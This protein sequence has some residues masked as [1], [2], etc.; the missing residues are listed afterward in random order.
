MAQDFSMRLP[1]VDPHGN[2]GSLDDSPAAS[3]YTEC[4]LSGFGL[5][6]LD[7]LDE[8]AVDFLPNYD[9]T[10]SEPAVLP[11]LFPNLL[12]NGST[13]V[14][15][16]MATNIPPHNLT[17]VLDASILLLTK[18]AS[19][20]DLLQVVKGPDF[21]TGGEIVSRADLRDLYATGKGSVSVRAKARIVDVSPRRKGIE[22]SELPYMV[23]PEKVV[24]RIRDLVGDKRLPAVADVKDFSDRT[25]GLRLVV[26]VKP[27]FDPSALLADL[28]RL[29]PME[30][31]F[32][33]SFVALVEGRP[34]VCSLRDL[35]Q[36]F[37]DHRLET[38]RRRSEFQLHR[39]RS[40]AHLQEALVLALDDV[41]AVVRL[42]R[43]ASDTADARTK[44][45]KRL[46][47]DATQ[48]DYVLEMP[49][50]RLTSLE[51]GK[52]R[53]DL[54]ALY[55][56]IS[57]LESLLASPK[58]LAAAVVSELS[59]LR[60]RFPSPRRTALSPS[61]TPAPAAVSVSDSP[62]PGGGSV[63]HPSQ[64]LL[65]GLTRS[66]SL[67]RILP[68]LG[69]ARPGV[70][71]AIVS[72]C[73]AGLNDRLLAISSSGRAYPFSP[74]EVPETL[75][76][77]RG[78][79]PVDL[80]PSFPPAENLVAVLPVSVP[81]AL[82]TARGVVKRLDPVSLP[83]NLGAPREQGF[84]LVSLAS[85]DELVAASPLSADPGSLDF[86]YVSSSGLVL[87]HPAHL[88][89]PQQ[90]AAA[91]VLGMSLAEGERVIAATA[92]SEDLPVWVC[93]DLGAVKGS[94]LSE[95]PR[96]GRATGGVLALRF[97]SGESSLIAAGFASVQ[98]FT[99]SAQPC[100]PMP[101]LAARSHVAA[102]LEAP[103]AWF[104]SPRP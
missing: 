97:R 27:G 15:V 13:G 85:G 49:L 75:R 41:D 9:G 65:V 34:K 48:A 94:S 87:R 86:V 35:L 69:R 37:V 52:I 47:I 88:V 90:R 68:G 24:A 3:R 78:V 46:S 20:D 14:A 36:S 26:E 74:A 101:A 51:V 66:G 58:R 44:L 6:L 40:R 31:A 100:G 54:A 70:H 57:R 32:P 67:S 96:K 56:E 23:G 98:A 73:L 72:G 7:G 80:F 4:R 61:F 12:V 19:L 50:R 45:V 2:F 103:A 95:F 93:T 21:P 76:A 30:E 84:S 29:T 10:E 55:K 11:A 17:E 33:A 83:A 82:F 89:R 63:S 79:A 42:I 53:K 28:Y 59:D 38:L 71:D 43:S 77:T 104:A 99:A 25:T 102:V 5:L 39:A 62:P 8:D 1:L 18:K 64:Q 91:G 60:E 16:G 22:I 81:L 92:G